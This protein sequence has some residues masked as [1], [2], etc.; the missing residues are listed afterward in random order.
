MKS[1]IDYIVFAIRQANEAQNFGFTRNHYSRNLRIALHQ[2]WQNKTMGLSGVSQKE[3][4]P[5][6]KAAVGKAKSE[7][8]V[9]HVVPVYS[10]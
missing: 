9:E 7:T 2:Y 3:N 5:R 6:S 8:I 4:I 10:S 1:N